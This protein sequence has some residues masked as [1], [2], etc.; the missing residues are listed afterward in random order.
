M[1]MR[2]N[3]K[4]KGK[5]RGISVT[6][7]AS[8]LKSFFSPLALEPRS[9]TRK[10]LIIAMGDCIPVRPWHDSPV[11]CLAEVR[12]I[13]R[14][15]TEQT[16]LLSLRL[17]V[18]PENSPKGRVGHGE[19]S[20]EFISL[21]KVLFSSSSFEAS[22]H[23][24]FSI[25]TKKI[26]FLSDKKITCRLCVLVR[27]GTQEKRKNNILV[28]R[29]IMNMNKVQLRTAWNCTRHDWVLIGG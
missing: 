4:P 16:L 5:R 2:K 21:E 1:V 17:Y 19:V 12:M 8:L 29:K 23:D 3:M 15:K 10:T 11:E 22:A 18:L 27:H 24:I 28:S 25:R 6:H 9:S 26:H 14:D 13:W 20:P 7:R